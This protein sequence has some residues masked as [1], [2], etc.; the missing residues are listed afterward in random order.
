ML[1]ISGMGTNMM[2]IRL[3][4]KSDLSIAT[5]VIKQSFITVANQFELT[6]VNA[7]TNAAFINEQRL[8]DDYDQGI[9]LYGL[10]RQDLMVGFVN[11]KKDDDN[12]YWLGKLAVS[13]EYRHNGYGR[14]LINHVISIVNDYN[15]K[16]V[17]IGI[18]NENKILKEWYSN[19]GFKESGI[20]KFEHLP[21][22]VCFM[23]YMIR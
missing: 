5:N 12:I 3:L 6:E 8:I 16:E 17:R 19:Q 18:I 22:E 4:S 1:L 2:E 7:P 14:M 21:F 10:F 20:R 9:L 11:L 13:P 23:K 15:G